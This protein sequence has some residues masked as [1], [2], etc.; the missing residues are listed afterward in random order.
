MRRQ[1]VA[2]G[3]GDRDVL[4][5]PFEQQAP[6]DLFPR[7]LD[8][9]TPSGDEKLPNT[10][11]VT[12]LQARALPAAPL[13]S[14]LSCYVKLASLGRESRTRVIARTDEPRWDET[15]SFRAA[16]WA[17][18]VT[19]SVRDRINV[20]ARVLGHL[21]ISCADVANLPGMACQSWFKLRSSASSTVGDAE[22]ELKVALVYTK[23][24]DPAAPVSDEP[25][26]LDNTA[27]GVIV[28][29]QDDETEAEAFARRKE[30]ERLDRERK[31]ALS[32]GL[33]Q[34]DYQVQ[35]HVIEARDLKGENVSE[36]RAVWVG[37]W[38]I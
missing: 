19:V 25:D 10:L 8:L 33:K 34:G 6:V 7:E 38:R 36:R 9:S 14:T 16:D 35:V 11:I 26:D 15:F 4:L 3:D 29:D 31:S 13:R 20:R 27:L 28:P 1:P 12:V 2:S 5:D 21:V 17:S 24:N 30:L 22:V 18:S 23:R 37:R 32:A